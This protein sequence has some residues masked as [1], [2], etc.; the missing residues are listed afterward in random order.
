MGKNYPNR[1]KVFLSTPMPSGDA[2]WRF[3]RESIDAF[4]AYSDLNSLFELTIIETEGGQSPVGVYTP[5][6]GKADVL[7]AVFGEKIPPGQYDEIVK[8]KEMS[9]IIFG[10]YLS[11][12]PMVGDGEN[13]HNVLYS[14]SPIN[15]ISNH[16]DLFSSIRTQLLG[17]FSHAIS[18][19]KRISPA[20]IEN[21]L[22]IAYDENNDE[23]LSRVGTLFDKVDARDENIYLMAVIYLIKCD[24]EFEVIIDDRLIGI[25]KENINAWL[26]L[27]VVAM[28][29]NKEDIFTICAENNTF[30]SEFN[31]LNEIFRASQ[32]ADYNTIML[33]STKFIESAQTLASR[34]VYSCR[35]FEEVIDEILKDY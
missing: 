23:L 11:Y 10:F 6:V 25:A 4:F 17:F 1:I 32:N 26:I 22:S 21:E 3:L 35:I 18:D 20:Y 13:N 2:H 27:L 15:P 24:L 16:Y 7:L 34:S 12:S 8:A 33:N 31:M 28:K 29:Y 5:M 19:V 9:K 30:Y 14:A